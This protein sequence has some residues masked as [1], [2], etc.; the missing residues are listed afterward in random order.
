[1]LFGAAGQLGRCLQDELRQEQIEYQAFSRTEVDITNAPEVFNYIQAFKPAIVV[2]LAAWT[3]VDGA[4]SHQTEAYVINATGAQNIAIA[5]ASAGAKLI[6]VSTDY[7]FDGSK[8]SPYLVDDSTNPLGVYGAT[9][10]SGEKLVVAAHPHGA[11][12]V[13]T[14][15]LYS[16]YGK[17]FAKSITQRALKGEPLSVINDTWG[18]PT[19][20]VDL[21]R[22]LIE[23]AFKSPPPGVFHATNAGEATWFD[24]ASEIISHTEKPSVITATTSHAFTS[25]A[26]RP[27]YSV[28]DHSCWVDN[29][30]MPMRNWK[31]A[32]TEVS[33]GIILA[34]QQELPR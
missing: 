28:L 29:G 20:G 5:C 31:D 6:H 32:L 3:D 17:N 33:R 34:V 1:M 25:I 23:L 19:S 7:V 30:I 14:A 22:Q 26:A 24:F 16:K 12:I 4:E 9:K 13:R 10:L 11:W 2:N 21:A 15:W 18:Q 8:G 27:K